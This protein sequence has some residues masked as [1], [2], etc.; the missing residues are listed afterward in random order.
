MGGAFGLIGRWFTYLVKEVWLRV[1]GGWSIWSNWQVIYLPSEGKSD[2]VLKEGGAFGLIDSLP[3]EGKSDWEL[4]V[5]G[6]FGLIDSLPSEGKSDWVLKEGG[7]FGLIDSLPSEG[8]SDWE[9]KVGGAFGLIDSL[10]S[11]G[12]SDWELKVGGAFGLIGRWFTYLVKGNLTESWRWAEHLV[13][14]AG[15]LL[16]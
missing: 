6:A 15:D 13:W 10:P 4:K 12:K 1:E 8:K 11:E 7:A 5:G 14:L 16:T 2:W 3:S 9:L